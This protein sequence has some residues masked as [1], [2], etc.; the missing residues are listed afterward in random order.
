MLNLLI[1][2][3]GSF[4]FP[5]FFHLRIKQLHVDPVQI[6]ILFKPTV[7]FAYFIISGSMFQSMLPLNFNYFFFVYDTATVISL[8]I[9][10]LH[11]K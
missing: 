8:I 4:V 7:V 3:N 11:I 10:N 6:F 2:A 9:N 1:Q 5:M